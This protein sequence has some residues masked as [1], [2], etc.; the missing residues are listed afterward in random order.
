MNI[1]VYKNEAQTTRARREQV[2]APAD[3]SVSEILM[4]KLAA[5][6]E[7]RYSDYS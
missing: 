3:A 4:T 1:L 2:S 7:E 6:D 5:K